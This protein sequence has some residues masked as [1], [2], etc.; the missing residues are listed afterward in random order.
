MRHGLYFN[1]ANLYFVASMCYNKII[2]KDLWLDWAG[3][4]WEGF[5]AGLGWTGLGWVGLG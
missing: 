5:V 1:A 4:G 3:L 2:R